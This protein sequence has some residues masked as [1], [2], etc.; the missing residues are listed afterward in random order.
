MSEN[1]ETAERK[2][3]MATLAKAPDGLLAKTWAQA[4]VTQDF[5]WLRAPE[6]GA[7]MVRGAM[8]GTGGAFNLGEIT[9]TRCAL[10][11]PDGAVGHAYIAG[12]DRKAAEIAAL[13]DALMQTESAAV[14][15]A[16]IL[17]PLNDVLHAKRRLKAEKAA[18]TKVDFFTL[19]RGED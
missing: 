12:R 16:R 1:T 17:T 14:V 19:A 18:A 6:I 10:R 7:V 4:G 11:L 5:E 2:G 13:C 9:V 8:G 3:W 15:R